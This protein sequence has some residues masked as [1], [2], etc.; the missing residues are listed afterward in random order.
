MVL[1]QK[2]HTA[3]DTI[4]YLVDY[5][6]WL[7]EGISLTAVTIALAP[8]S[9]ADV[10]LSGA[11][12]LTQHNRVAFVITGGSV[13]ENFTVAVQITDSRNEVKN[14]TCLFTVVAP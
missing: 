4:R 12:L 5:T 8:G 3:G 10:T 11:L 14:D 6:R 7:D 13:N 1:G 2:S 9:P